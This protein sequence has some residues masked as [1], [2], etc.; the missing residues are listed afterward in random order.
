VPSIQDTTFDK[1]QRRLGYT[2]SEGDLL[3]QAL[4]HR[5]HGSNN[6]ERLEFLGDSILN[7]VIAEDLY[8]RF[9]AAQEGKLS[10]L[11]AKMIK[12][13][14][15][16]EIAREFELGDYLIMGVGE[17]KSGGFQRDSILS[18][19][20]EAVIGA[21]FLDAHLDVVRERIVAWFASR[22]DILSLEKSFKDAKSRLQE[23]LQAR[24]AALPD[25]QVVKTEGQSHEQIFHVE[26]RVELL[27]E[28]AKGKGTSRR[29]AEQSAASVA[30]VNLGIEHHDR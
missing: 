13:Q 16:A 24:Q 23:F 25:Y 26:C 9:E 7:F 18:D 20:L 10:R 11:R 17:L 2:F 5:S 21:I 3:T 8:L 4:T 6:N 22:L 27:A 30:L 15:L 29:V 12:R 19:T 1:L 28:A 14:T